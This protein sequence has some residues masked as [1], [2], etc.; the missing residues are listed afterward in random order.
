MFEEGY[1]SSNEVIFIVV[2]S[3]IYLAAIWRIFEKAGK[4]G[5]AAL[6]PFYNCFVLLEIIGKPYWWFF[7]MFIPVVNIIFAVWIFNML[8]KSFGQGEGFTLGLILL[9]IIF[10][11]MLA[12]GNYE[13]QGPAGEVKR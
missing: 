13:Y 11:P 2:V 6:I 12:F 9:S 4:P 10:Y 5:W 8:S 1:F 7:M 3:V